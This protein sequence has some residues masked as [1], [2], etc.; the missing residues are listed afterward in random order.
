[1]KKNGYAS[2]AP[3]ELKYGTHQFLILIYKG[4]MLATITF[5]RPNSR[6]VK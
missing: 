6:Q 3:L 1:M 5:F 4:K 2:A